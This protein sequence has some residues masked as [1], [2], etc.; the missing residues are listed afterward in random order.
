MTVDEMRN[1]ILNDHELKDVNIPD[2]LLSIAMQY[3]E[4]R[5]NIT[6]ED[7]YIPVFVTDPDIE[8]QYVPSKRKVLE[9]KNE[10]IMSHLKMFD[11]DVYIQ[12]ASL[13]EFFQSTKNR[14]IILD[15]SKELIDSILNGTYE[16]GLYLYGKFSTGKTYLLSAIAHELAKHDITSTFVYMPDLVRTIKDGIRTGTLE[17][18]VNQ[19]KHTDVLIID[20]LGGENMTEWF[21]D[22]IFAPI[23]QFRHSLNLPVLISTN[24][25]FNNLTAHLLA[26]SNAK[27]DQIKVMRLV[28]RIQELSKPIAIFE[29]D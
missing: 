18:K 23:L 8:I 10:K 22:E 24:L 2:H 19:L 13:D 1:V 12:D 11:S 26:N 27:M 16:I 3:I 28:R 14:E 6:E 15:Y 5:D 4:I 7:D 20:D 17:E 25:D 9:M 21:R 29:I